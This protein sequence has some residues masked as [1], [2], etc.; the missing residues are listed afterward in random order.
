MKEAIAILRIETRQAHD[1][2]AR[3]SGLLKSCIQSLEQFRHDVPTGQ[4]LSAH[5]ND[6]SNLM[7]PEIE[8]RARVLH[9]LRF[10][11]MVSRY[12]NIKGAYEKTYEWIFSNNSRP[13]IHSPIGYFQERVYTGFLRS[14]DQENP[15]S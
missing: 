9:S 2:I 7:N 12:H 8:R 4:T 15:P 3:N 1:G 5:Y 10:D 6:L 13:C 11:N 14:L